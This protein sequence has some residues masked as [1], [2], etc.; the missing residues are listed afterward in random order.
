MWSLQLEYFVGLHTWDLILFSIR[1]FSLLPLRASPRASGRMCSLW[2]WWKYDVRLG[3]SAASHGDLKSS[4]RGSFIFHSKLMKWISIGG[5][6]FINVEL[7]TLLSM[8]FGCT[9][10]QSGSWWVRSFAG[11]IIY[12]TRSQ[13]LG[14][15]NPDGYLTLSARDVKGGNI[16]DTLPYLYT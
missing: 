16:V 12:T 6:L 3:K 14:L 13:T 1:S 10:F 5:I 9:R 2:H 8:E 7:L 4:K 11:C 15:P